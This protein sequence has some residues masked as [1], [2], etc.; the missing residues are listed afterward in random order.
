[1]ISFLSRAPHLRSQHHIH[2]PPLSSLQSYSKHPSRDFDQ[3]DETP[4][5]HH[6]RDL[7][8]VEEDEEEEEAEE[9]NSHEQPH[10]KHRTIRQIIRELTDL[11]SPHLWYPLAR[12]MKRNIHIHIGPTNRLV[13]PQF[14]YPFFTQTKAGKPTMLFNV[15][16]KLPL[17]SIVDR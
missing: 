13:N 5:D 15:F 9:F 16:L 12:K 17:L 1:M 10:S 6:S 11:R 14:T 2:I 4:H 3:A 7:S 8:H